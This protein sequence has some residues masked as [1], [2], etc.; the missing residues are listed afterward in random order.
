MTP[1]NGP[2][3]VFAFL[4]G[5]QIGRELDKKYDLSGK[6]AN[7]GVEYK[8]AL[9]DIGIPEQDADLAGG[10]ASFITGASLG[11]GTA[12]IPFFGDLLDE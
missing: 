2:A 10:A 5:V 11:L 6:A 7:L 3:L 1:A 9:L 12:A 8:E 4:F